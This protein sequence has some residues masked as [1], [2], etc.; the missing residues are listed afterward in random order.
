MKAEVFF[1][2][3]ALVQPLKPCELD[4]LEKR[5]SRRQTARVEKCRIKDPVARRRAV[6]NRAAFKASVVIVGVI[7][8]Y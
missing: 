2:Q 5:R 7:Q 3:Q 4:R 6:D 1:S 8:I